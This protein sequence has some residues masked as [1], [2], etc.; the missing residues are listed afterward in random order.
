MTSAS[1][2]RRYARGLLFSDVG[3]ACNV[4]QIIVNKPACT[5]VDEQP[6]ETAMFLHSSNRFTD[7]VS[8]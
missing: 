7:T 6:Q 1:A 3:L 4:V 5:N 2:F 8:M